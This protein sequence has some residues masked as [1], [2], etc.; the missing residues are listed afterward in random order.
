V[1]Q[2]VRD[3]NAIGVYSAFSDDLGDEPPSKQTVAETLQMLAAKD[4]DSRATKLITELMKPFIG[5]F[6]M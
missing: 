4:K 5:S 3:L 2:E 1:E 6:T